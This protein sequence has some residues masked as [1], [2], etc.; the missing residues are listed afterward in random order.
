[1]AQKMNV[2]E[3]TGS[4]TDIHENLNTLFADAYITEK[5]IITMKSHIERLV[6]NDER[7][8]EYF[9]IQTKSI[10]C[11]QEDVII[12]KNKQKEVFATS[13]FCG[14]GFFT[15]LAVVTLIMRNIE[16]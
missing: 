12:L 13:F 11:L 7:F 15:S 6:T 10:R 4:I 8:C 2:N 16:R 14:V 9:K 3:I 5:D 1:M